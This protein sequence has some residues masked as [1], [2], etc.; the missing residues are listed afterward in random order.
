MISTKWPW[1]KTDPTF[2]VKISGEHGKIVSLTLDED[3]FE[4]LK[5]KTVFSTVKVEDPEKGVRAVP[6][7]FLS[8]VVDK[9][10]K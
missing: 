4:R 9:E 7:R 1:G 10:E 2:L 3:T 5:E 6:I 8:R